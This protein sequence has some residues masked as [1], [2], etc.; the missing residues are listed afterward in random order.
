MGG[1]KYGWLIE[2][3]LEAGT[4]KLHVSDEKHHEDQNAVCYSK[5]N[6]NHVFSGGDNGMVTCWDSRLFGSR[7]SP[8]GHLAGHTEGITYIDTADD[9]YTIL[10]NCKD[11]TIK[12]WDIRM[13]T[14]EGAAKRFEREAVENGN[15]WDYRYNF[16]PHK[17]ANPNIVVKEGLN[18]FIYK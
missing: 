14:K 4:N 9:G 18:R 10:T 2:F 3:D 7:E 1:S 15:D 11:Q 17:Y 12:L 5:Q 6:T 13:F 16:L 8:V